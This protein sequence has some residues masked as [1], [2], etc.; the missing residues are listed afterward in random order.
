L[1]AASHTRTRL[2]DGRCSA[3]SKTLRTSAR[4]DRRDPGFTVGDTVGNQQT[5]SVGVPNQSGGEFNSL[6]VEEERSAHPAQPV[7]LVEPDEPVPAVPAESSKNA[8]ANRREQ[9]RPFPRPSPD[10]YDR[11]MR[12]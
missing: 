11:S 3:S 2:P 7:C 6:L 9:K 10:A 8:A 12:C 4:V 1:A 5:F